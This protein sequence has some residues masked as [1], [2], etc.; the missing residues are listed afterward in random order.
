MRVEMLFWREISQVGCVMVGEA[1]AHPTA[2]PGRVESRRAR[3]RVRWLFY[4]FRC[5]P[6]SSSHSHVS[7]SRLVQPSVRI[8]RTGLSCW[9]LVEAYATYRAGSTFGFW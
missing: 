5:G 7:S 4:A 6:Q 8:S 2:T 1:V 3:F 9:L